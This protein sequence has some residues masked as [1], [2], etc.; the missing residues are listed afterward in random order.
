LRYLSNDEDSATRTH[1]LFATEVAFHVTRS[2]FFFAFI[3]ERYCR[4]FR[5]FAL[6]SVEGFLPFY[7]FWGPVARL[8]VSGQLSDEPQET[9]FTYRPVFFQES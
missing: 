2:V 3:L 5:A 8:E 4:I 6:G 1:L 9:L 7:P